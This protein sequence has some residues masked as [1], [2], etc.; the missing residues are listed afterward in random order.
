MAHHLAMLGPKA[1]FD[2]VVIDEGT[3]LQA[4]EAHIARGVRLLK[5]KYRLVLTG[6]P[7]KNRLE[8]IFWL[9]SWVAG[10][11]EEGTF[12]YPATPKAREVFAEHFLMQEQSIAPGATPNKNGSI[13]HQTN[14]TA[15]LTNL[16]ELWEILTPLII[17][18][19]K[20]D[21]GEELPKKILKPIILQMG[22]EQAR[23][24]R[25][26]LLHPPLF[27]QKGRAVYGF[28]RTAMQLNLLRQAALCPHAAA[29]GRSRSAG[30]EPKRSWTDFTPKLGAAL[31]LIAD[32]LDRGE[33]VL[34]GSPFREFSDA[35]Q[36][37][38]REARVS[39]LLLDGR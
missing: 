24:Y 39:S 29:L 17:R 13:K 10:A 9:L 25:Q 27:S 38:L 33:Q 5:P 8:S 32:L 4:D 22:T 2:C 14:R 18:M 31:A 3:R 15:R 37:R 20:A 6:T 19:R 1:G 35:I 11:R 34:V 21:C 30:L 12:P 23:V 7:I 36:Y 16:H 26:H 28:G